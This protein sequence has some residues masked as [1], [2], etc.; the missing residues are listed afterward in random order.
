M[1]G[2]DGAAPVDAVNGAGL[3]RHC[4]EF[5]KR[6]KLSG[7]PEEL[8]SFRYLQAQLDGFGYRTTLLSHDALI[9]LPGAARV[10][11]DGATLRAITHSFSLPSPPGGLTATLAYVGEGTEADFA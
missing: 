6:V 11:A 3:M 7:T 2:T 1:A 9:S 8:E 4:V 5:A 10:E